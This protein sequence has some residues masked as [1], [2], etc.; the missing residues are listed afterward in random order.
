MTPSQTNF[1]KTNHQILSEI[2]SEKLSTLTE[3]LFDGKIEERSAKIDAINVLR[4][5]LREI[6]MLIK[7]EAKSTNFV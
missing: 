3:Q 2:F 4:D 5:W 6:D 7:P 1:I